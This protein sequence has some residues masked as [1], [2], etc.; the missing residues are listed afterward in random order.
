[1]RKK[2]KKQKSQTEVVVPSFAHQLYSRMAQ[3]QTKPGVTVDLGGLGDG[4]CQYI[5]ITKGGYELSINF[6]GTG[7]DVTDIQLFK[8]VVQVV[9]HTK[10]WDT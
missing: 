7:E 5:S 8:Q 1:M 9:D 2:K 4:S 10:V 3:L 6:D